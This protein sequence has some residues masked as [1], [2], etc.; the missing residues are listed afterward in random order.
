V[1]GVEPG[2][3]SASLRFTLDPAAPNPS[4]TTTSFRFSTAQP[5]EADAAV[6]DAS[7]RRVR[8]VSSGLL[9]GEGVLTWDGRSEAGERAPAG[10]YFLRV[11]VAGETH[12]RRFVRMR[13]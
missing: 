4:A 11:R 7:G 12:V 1:T 5:V 2:V 13:S 6:Y 3:P 8:A 10:I 9:S